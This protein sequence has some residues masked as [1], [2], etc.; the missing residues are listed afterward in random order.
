[1][2][3][4]KDNGKSSIRRIAAATGIA[5]VPCID[6]CKPWN[7]ATSAQ[8][9]YFW[10]TPAGQQWCAK[11]V[12]ATVYGLASKNGVDS[13]TLSAFFHLLH[14]RVQVG[15]PAAAESR[16]GWWSRFWHTKAAGGETPGAGSD[17]D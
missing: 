9:P 10:E 6:T 12:L 11:L 2:P 5:K 7:A 8:N 15:F 4:C 3:G 17:S 14:L 1:L 13:E 16:G